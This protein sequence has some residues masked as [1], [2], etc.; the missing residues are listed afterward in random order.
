MIFSMLRFGSRLLIPAILAA[1]IPA[2]AAPTTAVT[3]E[4]CAADDGLQRL[5]DAIL[6]LPLTHGPCV[7]DLWRDSPAAEIAFR[8]KLLEERRLGR[9]RRAEDGAIEVEVSLP[10]TRAVNLI[11]EV[12]DRFVKD[13][14]ETS[15]T[16]KDPAATV[17]ATG[18]WRG[19]VP[20]P[21]GPAGWR[22]CDARRMEMTAAAARADARQYLLEG[23]GDWQLSASQTV[24]NIWAVRPDFRQAVEKLAE[25]LSLPEPTFEPTGLC[26]VDAR[27]ERLEIVKLLLAAA[28]DCATPVEADLGSAIDPDARET[29]EVAGFAVAPP[30]A[31]RIRPP[32]SGEQGKAD[33]DRPEWADRSLSI[34]VPGRAPEQVA[35][36]A[37]RLRMATAAATVEAK[38][39]LWLQIENLPLRPGMSELEASAGLL[40]DIRRRHPTS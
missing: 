34:Q 30:F 6:A 19:P 10:G 28:R 32:V 20:Q 11:A 18:R 13:H 9:A 23:I 15:I 4:Q 12:T 5:A 22:H 36:A 27:F 24:G 33:A 35:D 38:R 2:W 3:A 17:S 39:R 14:E 37:E 31:P 7:A 21:A 26:R 16:L 25:T 40:Q 1:S 8:R 29:F